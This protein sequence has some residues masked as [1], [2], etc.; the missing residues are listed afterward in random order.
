MA[1]RELRVCV[2][3]CVVVHGWMAHQ[4][5]V[6]LHA[7]CTELLDV[8]QRIFFVQRLCHDQR[9][10]ERGWAF[11]WAPRARVDMRLPAP[12]R[13]LLCTEYSLPYPLLLQYLTERTE[14]AHRRNSNNVVPEFEYLLLCNS[15]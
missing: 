4:S 14:E 6:C 8:A 7:P 10:G 9:L 12:Y 15:N 11:F 13:F 2:C 3:V 1:D 5:H